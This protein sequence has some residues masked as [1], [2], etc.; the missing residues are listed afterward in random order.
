MTPHAQDIV[1]KA[2]QDEERLDAALCELE[3][4]FRAYTLITEDSASRS[5]DRARAAVFIRDQVELRLAQ[6]RQRTGLDRSLGEQEQNKT[7]T[8]SVD[9]DANPSTSSTKVPEEKR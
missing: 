8:S 4:A 9:V 2:Y 7:K 5:P 1:L 3:D 6:L